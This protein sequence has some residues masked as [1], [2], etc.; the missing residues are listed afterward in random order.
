[1]REK[2][3]RKRMSDGRGRFHE[4]TLHQPTIYHINRNCS[5]VVIG[6]PGHRRSR[7]QSLGVYDNFAHTQLPYSPPPPSIRNQSQIILA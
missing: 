3:T 6:Y 4:E 2:D 1:M 5:T 7:A